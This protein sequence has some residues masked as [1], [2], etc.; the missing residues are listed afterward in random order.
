MRGKIVT[1]DAEK[2]AL[3]TEGKGVADRLANFQASYDELVQAFRRP[4]ITRR[5][6]AEEP[7]VE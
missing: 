2:S 5:Y 3:E 7:G 6:G 1:A 4:S